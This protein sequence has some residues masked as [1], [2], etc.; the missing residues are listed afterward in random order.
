MDTPLYP[1]VRILP[2]A[3]L[4]ISNKTARKQVK[5]FLKDMQNRPSGNATVMV[6]L[7]K[8][9]DALATEAKEKKSS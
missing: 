4:S 1:P 6:Q 3:S 5:S 7:Q 9:S 2:D 8:L